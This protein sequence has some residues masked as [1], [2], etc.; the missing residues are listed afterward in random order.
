MKNYNH[1]TGQKNTVDILNQR[2]LNQLFSFSLLELPIGVM[3]ITYMIKISLL[4]EPPIIISLTF[5]PLLKIGIVLQ[6]QIVN[7]DY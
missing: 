4:F 7:K 5:H 3:I 6:F 1:K 2:L